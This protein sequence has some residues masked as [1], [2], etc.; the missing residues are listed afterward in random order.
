MATW[1]NITNAAVAAGAAVT[2]SLMTALRDNQVAFAERDAT[3][4]KILGSPYDYQEFLVSG[5]WTKPANAETG[6]VVYV[7]VVGGGGAG[8]RDNTAAGGGGGAGIIHRFYNIDDLGST[9]TVIV[10]AGGA[11]GAA[12]G[13]SGGASSFGTAGASATLTPYLSCGGGN[14]AFGTTGG[15]GGSVRHTVS[16]A[17]LGGDNYGFSGGNGGDNGSAGDSSI[18]GG[19]GG[20]GT[21]IINGGAG[22]LS[23]YAGRGGNGTDTSGPVTDYPIDGEFPGGGGGGVATTLSGDTRGGNGADGVVRVWCVKDE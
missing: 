2:T 23:A 3:A 9:E 1:T 5:T 12:N 13:G 15:N 6:D 11:G 4:P 21:A 14:A 18:F 20:G 22:G 19:G 10:G 8:S 16:N 7:H 17:T